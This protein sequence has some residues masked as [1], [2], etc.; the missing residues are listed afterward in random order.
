MRLLFN[1]VNGEEIEYNTE[2]DSVSIGRSSKCDVVIPHESMSRQHCKIEFK[3][4]DIFITDLGSINGVYIDGVKIPPNSSVP[5]HTYLHLAFG[6]VT[7]AQLVV[8]ENTRLGILN[9]N[10]KAAETSG[11]L[12]SSL[13]QSSTRTRTKV[14]QTKKAEPVKSKPAPSAQSEKTTIMIKGIAFV[15]IMIALYFF[16]YADQEPTS[17]TIAPNNQPQAAPQATSTTDHF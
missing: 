10:A 6:Y 7:S 5:F 3:D 17:T 8:D 14:A 9:P 1:L 13:N 16:L 11:P 4:S 15:G 12:Q 2:K